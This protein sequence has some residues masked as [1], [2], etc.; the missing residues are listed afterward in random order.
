[1][2]VDAWREWSLTFG[3]IL[4]VRFLWVGTVK[5]IDGVAAWKSER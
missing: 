3:V 4:G 2:A 5:V 1:V